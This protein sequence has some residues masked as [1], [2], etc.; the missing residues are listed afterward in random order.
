MANKENENDNEKLFWKIIR[1][2]YLFKYIIDIITTTPIIYDDFK[3]IHSFNRIK[4]KYI[5]SLKFMIEKNLYQLIKYKL[6][7]KEEIIVDI[8]SII[9]LVRND[10]VVERNNQ[11]ETDEEKQTKK[12]KETIF[13]LI[14]ENFILNNPQF[15]L[16]EMVIKHSNE[17][18]LNILV[19][20]NFNNN[21][22]K[23]KDSHIKTAIQMSSIGILKILINSSLYH[24]QQQQQQQQQ[25]QPDQT[26]QDN[27]DEE[28]Q[29]YLINR[30]NNYLRYK[31]Y[32]YSQ[33]KFKSLKNDIINFT[34]KIGCNLEV[35]EFILDNPIL[36]NTNTID[37][38]ISKIEINEFLRIKSF[39]IKKRLLNLDYV[40][41]H[42]VQSKVINNILIGENS[43]YFINSDN[44]LNDNSIQGIEFKKYLKILTTLDSECYKYYIKNYDEILDDSNVLFDGKI[45]EELLYIFRNFNLDLFKKFV[46]RELKKGK[47][48]FNYLNIDKLEI[49]DE[50]ATT[51]F[52]K[53]SKQSVL[54]FIKYYTSDEIY[55]NFGNLYHDYNIIMY[56][57]Y[58]NSATNTKEEYLEF[59]NS[60]GPGPDNFPM[61]LSPNLIV[62]LRNQSLHSYFPKEWNIFLKE[63]KNFLPQID[64]PRIN[65]IIINRETI[66]WLL[67]TYEYSFFSKLII[68]YIKSN[69]FILE[70]ID[71]VE[72]V[73]KKL[74]LNKNQMKPLYLCSYYNAIN[75]CN[76]NEIQYLNNAIN[77]CNLKFDDNGDG[78]I[79][80]NCDLISF[81]PFIEKTKQKG[82]ENYE[83]VCKTIEY[84]FSTNF[85][86]FT[87]GMFR[88]F[89]KFFIKKRHENSKNSF[90]K[91]DTIKIST[92]IELFDEC[93][94]LVVHSLL[95]TNTIDF[96][97]HFS[98]D[99]L[100]I[101]FSNL[102]NV[103]NNYYKLSKGT[104]DD[105]IECIEFLFDFYKK[106]NIDIFLEKN[107]DSNL[108]IQQFIFKI[109]GDLI[110][111]SDISIEKI[112]Q[113][114]QLIE[115]ENKMNHQLIID[116]NSSLFQN[117]YLSKKSIYLLKWVKQ[118]HNVRSYS[119]PK[120]ELSFEYIFNDETSFDDIY[121]QLI[122]FQLSPIFTESSFSSNETELCNNL[123]IFC[124]DINRIDLF[125]KQLDIIKLKM[126][127]F[128]YNNENNKYQFQFA[129][130]VFLS[131]IKVL[132]P[133][134]FQ[135]FLCEHCY[136]EFYIFYTA[137]L[138]TPIDLYDNFDIIQ[139][140]QP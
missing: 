12:E 117:S 94:N 126:K 36:Y 5:K 32:Q 85:K 20:Y 63:Y 2:K 59:I 46:E 26:R 14:L 23:I 58:S 3:K 37:S 101:L 80:L 48:Y 57:F 30:N 105:I 138:S 81:K 27:E 134:S 50:N 137:H 56:C 93:A 40:Q 110:S 9:L 53:K 114:Y 45:R 115:N 123:L 21:V 136:V 83:K 76:L 65:S 70:S 90:I 99:D 131:A 49:N 11:I 38:N 13:L 61:K 82:D 84:I 103:T 62:K 111:R 77:N 133:T 55:K 34:I 67:N 135:L 52:N 17:N 106:S 71:L 4:F 79:K 28:T 78:D 54:E 86:Y 35:L 92:S 124:L 129:K 64:G 118:I 100:I 139:Q 29:E 102:K 39:K 15:D 47:C 66:D 98:I 51:N 31:P 122:S 125:F 16:L 120:I 109:Y 24:R 130:T 108:T 140:H 72:S 43:I 33:I 104:I 7:N 88:N 75:N 1:N 44:N 18:I 69:H 74:D 10:M 128:S 119:I 127:S 113:V 8:S 96:V 132:D 73:I 87:P 89:I 25:Q 41:Y 42:K 116:L 60:I 95:R 112:K 6:E 91:D 121:K 22:L 97:K 68:G 19:N 107:L